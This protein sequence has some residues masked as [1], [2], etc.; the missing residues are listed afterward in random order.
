MTTNPIYNEF[1]WFPSSNNDWDSEN[2][3]LSSYS[4][5]DGVIIKF[6][7]VNQYENNLFIDNINISS[8]GSTFINE[9]NQNSLEIYP[10]PA[11]KLVNINHDGLKEIY[12]VLGEKLIE[13]YENEINISNIA[14]GVY[15]VKVANKTMRLIK[16]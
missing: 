10:N 15:L 11:D 7:N 4:N 5:L 2:I 9:E 12:T 6:R 1:E 16:E 13:T 3:S 14:K 8:D